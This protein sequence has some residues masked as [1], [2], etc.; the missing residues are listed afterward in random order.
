VWNV[1]GIAGLHRDVA[2]QFAQ[3]SVGYARKVFLARRVA[4]PAVDQLCVGLRV[5]N[6]PAL[7][8]AEGLM[9]DSLGIG[10]VGMH[11]HGK[12]VVCGNDL[13]QYRKD[14]LGVDVSQQLGA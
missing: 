3:R 6:V 14:A 12:P 1:N 11:L 5:E 7:R 10:V 8:L 4:C 9:L 13:R 2:Q